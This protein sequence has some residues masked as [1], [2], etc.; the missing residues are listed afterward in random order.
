MLDKNQVRIEYA[1]RRRVVLKK[2]SYIKELQEGLVNLLTQISEA[3]DIAGYFPT[4][5]ELNIIPILTSLS[6]SGYNILLPKIVSRETMSFVKW[7]G[8]LEKNNNLSFLEPEG[9]DVQIPDLVITPLICCDIEG[10]RIGYGKGFYDRYLANH[11]DIVKVAL[12][13]EE[14]ITKDI[15]KSEKHDVRL[16]YIITE[17]EIIATS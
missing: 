11:K 4:D 14:L 7:N 13:P 1:E 8:K 9:L 2:F 15:I 16:D 17:K 5:R 10:N 3:S 12:I 6:S